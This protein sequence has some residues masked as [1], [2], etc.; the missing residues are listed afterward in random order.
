MAYLIDNSKHDEN[1][2]LNRGSVINDPSA[3]KDQEKKVSKSGKK[4]G[5]T[6]ES[7]RDALIDEPERFLKNGQASKREI[8]KIKDKVIDEKSF[9]KEVRNIWG[10]DS[11]LKNLVDSVQ[12]GDFHN[13]FKQA[14]IQAWVKDNKKNLI[15]PFLAKNLF[16]KRE[17]AERV[18]NLLSEYSQDKLL[19]LQQSG[20][21]FEFKEPAKVPAKRTGI[22]RQPFTREQVDFLT[23]NKNMKPTNLT[24]AFNGAFGEKR[25]VDTI[26]SRLKALRKQ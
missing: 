5:A 24:N 7:G 1:M 15:V 13:L 14:E 23:R 4:D 20:R 18:Y 26:E 3:W 2:A 12:D 17:K 19:K 25:S 21:T 8:L 11:G 22:A 9:V 16:V 10:K 6:G